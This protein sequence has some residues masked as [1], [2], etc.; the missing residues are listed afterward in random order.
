[1]ERTLQ[2]DKELVNESLH[3]GDG[4]HA[5]QSYLPDD[6][7]KMW[8]ELT[9]RERSIIVYLLGRQARAEQYD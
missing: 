5:W 1:M 7:A 4:I 6:L 3:P 9:D 2:I 8:K